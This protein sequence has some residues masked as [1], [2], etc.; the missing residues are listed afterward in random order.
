MAVADREIYELLLEISRVPVR[1]ENSVDDLLA[2][3]RAFNR[4][5]SSESNTLA[6]LRGSNP[7]ASTKDR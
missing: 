5:L 3:A 2:D 1:V 6:T 7:R 4:A